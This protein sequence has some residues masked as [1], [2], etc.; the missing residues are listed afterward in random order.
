MSTH[1]HVL[2]VLEYM[3]GGTL[4]AASAAERGSKTRKLGW[5]QQSLGIVIGIAPGHGLHNLHTQR[6]SSTGVF[7]SFPCWLPLLQYF[8]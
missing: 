4:A 6:V 1:M 7:V 3:Q 8:C 5:K 2:V